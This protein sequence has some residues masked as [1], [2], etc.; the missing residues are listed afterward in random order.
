MATKSK[1]RTSREIRTGL[2]YPIVDADGHMFEFSHLFLDYIRTEGGINFT[3]R[4][5]ARLSDPL[6]GKPRPGGYWVGSGDLSWKARR[7]ARL[8][9]GPFW[10]VPTKNTLDAATATLPKLLY[11]RMDE[12]ALDFTILYG[13]GSLPLELDDETRQVTVRAFNSMQANVY[14]DYRDRMTPAAI[15]PMHTPR[16][17]L[18][19][20]DYA[21]GKL[22]HK[23]IMI[24]PGVPRPIPAL[25]RTHPTAFPETCWVDTYA[26]DSAHDYD[27]VW[28]RCVELQ[29][30]VTAHGGMLLNFPWYGRSISN[31][32]YNH[33]G[34]HAFQ[35]GA[36]CKALFLGGVTR[37]FPTLNFAFLEGGAGWACTMLVELLG[38]WEKRSLKGLENTKPTNLDSRR[39]LELLAKYGGP[40]VADRLDE[41][42]LTLER[43]NVQIDTDSVDEWAA[44]QVTNKRELRDLFVPNFYFGCEADDPTLAWAFDPKVNPYKSRLNAVFGSDISHYDV[45]DMA[46]VV[47]EAYELH[48][49]GLL[50]DASLRDFLFTNP[51]RL[52]GGM[53]PHFFNGTPVEA[54]AAKLLRAPQKK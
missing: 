1:H 39:Y 21:V 37:R 54:A 5:L 31:F 50:D 34:N 14:R 51:V 24:P 10:G 12:L 18:A 52:H 33:L 20:L 13:P 38:A 43:Q 41:V 35:Q 44:L 19:E 8:R 29:V 49:V 9:R 17:A 40:G 53:N 16:E 28:A 48:E 6:V 47:A 32:V 42:R 36:L 30:A 45:P 4:Y 22:G 7:E 46:R 25:Q 3:R 2:S 15:I 27:P 11:A 23:V 26:L